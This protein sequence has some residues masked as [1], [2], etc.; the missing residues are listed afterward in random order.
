M[1]GHTEEAL[2][3]LARYYQQREETDRQLRNA[4]TYPAILLLMMVAV[5]WS[6]WWKFCRSLTG[7]TPP[8]AEA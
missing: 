1:T 7:S 6:C 3:S 8:W 2:Q 5:I 4:I